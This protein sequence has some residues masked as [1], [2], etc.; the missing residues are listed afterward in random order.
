MLH[1]PR[2]VCLALLLAAACAEGGS[3][4][5][6]RMF[7][8]HAV[9]QRDDPIRFSG[10]AA[11]GARIRLIWNGAEVTSA[12]ADNDGSWRAALP[13][14]PPG[15]PHVLRIESDGESPVVLDDLM[16]GDVWFLTGQSNAW[17]PL[18]NAGDPEKEIAAATDGGIRFLDQGLCGCTVEL[19]EP[20][21]VMGWNRCSPATARDFPALGYHFARTL[22]ET[23]GSNIVVGVVNAAW[24]GPPIAHFLPQQRNPGADA[25]SLACL[26]S[27]V[28]ARAAA[29]LVR[30]RLLALG[31]DDEAL[32]ALAATDPDPAR[33]GVLDITTDYKRKELLDCSGLLRLRRTF[34]LPEE[35][36]EQALMLRLG[37]FQLPDRTYLNGVRVGG[38]RDFAAPVPGSQANMVLPHDYAIPDGVARPGVNVLDVF[39]AAMEPVSWWCGPGR[40][41]ALVADG[42]PAMT[43]PIAGEW[44]YERTIPIPT[45]PPT[46]G[47][48][49]GGMIHPFFRMGVKGV[50]FYQGESDRTR[51]TDYLASHM[52]LI[53]LLREGWGKPDLP[54]YFVQLAMHAPGTDVATGD[55]FA[56]VREAQRRT[57][58]LPHTGMAVTIDIGDE[59]NIHP[60]DK[61]EAG[62]RL[63][64]QALVKTYG[65]TDL[66][67][68]GPL[69]IRFDPTP[70]GAT[71]IYD[72]ATLPLVQRGDGPLPG[73]ETAS[74]DGVFQPAAASIRDGVVRLT[75]PATPVRAV[76]YLYRNVPD[77]PAALYNAA[78]LPAT[79]FL[80][81]NS[82]D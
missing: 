36:A 39:L 18:R 33:G 14:M 70:D 76:R 35:L 68:D 21:F 24:P 38:L 48:A 12:T 30:E 25:R 19:D 32:A 7:S 78:G 22:R 58:A 51:A 4:R 41:A 15:G 56:Q 54:F 47:N 10:E 73:F 1:I 17:W 23:L 27:N 3:L 13:A 66:V 20:P 81:P 82:W 75:A 61:R 52:R 50:I 9:L 74:D 16:V 71:V 29:A 6:N 65:R 63:A 40:D 45:P 37:P 69:P 28:A 67:A 43:L 80:L 46:F 49:W 11:P 2:T 42:E 59:R 34:T 26:A 5:I 72:P 31:D 8:S 64:L 62:R 57:L 79:P 60:A 44:Q 55:G 53:E 77:P